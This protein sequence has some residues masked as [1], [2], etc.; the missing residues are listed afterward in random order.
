MTACGYFAPVY[1]TQS[2]D[3][4]SVDNGIAVNELAAIKVNPIADRM[5]HNVRTHLEDLLNPQS[6]DVTPKYT[7]DIKL[8]RTE[9]P[10]AIRPDRSAASVQM[11]ILAEYV[12]KNRETGTILDK[13]SIKTKGSY[14]RLESEF[15]TYTAQENETLHIGQ[16]IAEKFRLRLLSVFYDEK[17]RVIKQENHV[18]G[19][20]I[21]EEKEE[22]EETSESAEEKTGTVSGGDYENKPYTN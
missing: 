14:N 21:K 4:A 2:T 8:T 16:D 11:L 17:Q 20:E 1:G 13:G 3:R 15:G 9:D 6:L 22:K 10:F 7:L 19:A 18:S 5:G 12:L